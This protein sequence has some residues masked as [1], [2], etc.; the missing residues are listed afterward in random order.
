MRDNPRFSPDQVKHFARKAFVQVDNP[1]TSQWTKEDDIRYQLISKPH[2]HN[3]VKPGTKTY[4]STK[5]LGELFDMLDGVGDFEI[6]FNTNVEPEMNI[7]IRSRIEKAESKDHVQVAAIRED[8]LARLKRFNNEVLKKVNP[9]W[10]LC[11]QHRL[12]IEKE[13][14]DDSTYDL[15]DV[16]A[17]LYAVTYFESREKVQ[18]FKKE[19]YVFAWEVAH[20]H[21]TRIFADGNKTR[22]FAPTV[23]RGYELRT[24]GR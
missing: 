24:F 1:H 23:A 10:V 5:V 20:D 19:P 16:F 21:L 7:H 2:W 17:I 11:E 22:G 14:G 9:V 18:R 6:D 4:R 8:M 12:E 15:S 13:Y 3:K